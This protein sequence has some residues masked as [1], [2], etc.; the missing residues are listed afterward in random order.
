LDQKE[1]DSIRADYLRLARAAREK[2]QE[3]RSGTPEVAQPGE[4]G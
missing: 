3:N 1:L 2:L 4:L